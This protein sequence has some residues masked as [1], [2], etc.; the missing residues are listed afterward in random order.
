MAVSSWAGLPERFALA[1][2]YHDVARVIGWDRAVSFGMAVWHQKRPPLRN[3]KN[4]HGVVYIPHA[5]GGQLGR[6]GAELIRLAGESDAALLVG[7]FCGLSLEFPNIV[8]TSIGRRN[9]AITQYIADGLRPAVVACAFGI[10]DRQA[11]RIASKE[12][13]ACQAKRYLIPHQSHP[14]IRA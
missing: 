8:S 9:R 10:T 4:G 11:R 3:H 1:P 13:S 2:V 7:A 12:L 6:G 14:K 5:L